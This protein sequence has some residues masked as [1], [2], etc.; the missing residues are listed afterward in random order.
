M[1][2]KE[3]IGISSAVG[4]PIGAKPAGLDESE[5]ESDV[6]LVI[7]QMEIESCHQK[8]R[9]NNRQTAVAHSPVLLFKIDATNTN[10]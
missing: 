9:K 1:E 4:F 5:S 7:I 2:N 6:R 3:V 8:Q 10:R